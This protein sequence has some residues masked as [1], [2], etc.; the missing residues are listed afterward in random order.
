MKLL[1]AVKKYIALLICAVMVLCLG[2]CSKKDE[3]TP[4]KIKP[5]PAFE[6][7]G[8]IKEGRKNIYF[9]VKDLNSSY[10]RVVINGARAASED[11]D[12]NVYYSGCYTEADWQGMERLLDEAVDAGADAVVVSPNNSV[13]LSGKISQIYNNG[14][15]MVLVDTI[16]NTDQYD[17]CYMTDNLMAGQQAAA[18]MITQLKANGNDTDEP[19]RIGIEIGAVSSQTVNE[20]LAG[21]LQYWSNKAPDNW[22]VISD[23]KYNNGDNDNAL[24][25]AEDLLGN[26]NIKGVYGTDNVSTI[27]LA[28]TI[29]AHQRTDVVMIGFDFSQEM[30]TLIMTDGYVA[31]TMVQRQFEMAHMG[32]QT[33]LDIINGK[34]TDVKFFDTGITIVSRKNVDEEKV[35]SLLDK[36]RGIS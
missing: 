19:L 15:P 24:V 34:K 33:A 26:E 6:P 36:D 11:F 17:I 20:R 2:G 28:K 4:I 18:E 9:I 29:L 30:E 35:R 16:A 25:C 31:S 8:D 13:K 12:C 3:D 22:E 27:G 32:V 21:F 1:I 10:W 23:I 7:L 5:A 14:I